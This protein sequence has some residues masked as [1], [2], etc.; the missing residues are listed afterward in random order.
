MKIYNNMLNWQQNKE[1]FVANFFYMEYNMEKTR[2]DIMDVKV[3]DFIK[4]CN[5]K[6]ICGN[7]ETICENFCKDSRE[8]KLGDTYLGIKG[9]N[10]NGS[11]YYKQA[12]ENGAKVLILQDVEVEKDIVKKYKDVSIIFV[13]NVVKAIQDVARYKRENSNVKVVGITGSVGKTS[14]KDI[15]ASVLSQKYKVL[16]T[17]GNYNNEIGLPLTILSLK[18]EEIMVL[19]MGMS[20]FGEMSLLTSI[21]KPD[22]AA[23]TNI[24]TSHIGILGS[25]E[26]ILKAKLEILEGLKEDGKLIINN[27][28]DLLNKWYLEEKTIS[29]IKTYG[30]NNNSNYTAYEIKLDEDGSEYKI[31]I[32][33]KI[34]NVKVPVN[35][36]HF[37]Y[38]S[39][40]AIA[41]GRELGV[42]NEDIIKGISCF[43]LT[44]KR[45]EMLKT[46]NDILII[47][48][49]YNASYDSMKAAIEYLGTL[50]NR[51]IAILG[52]MLELG[53]FSKEL[54]EKVGK[55]TAKN[56]INILITIGEEAKYIANS[57]EKN[58]I[59]KESI[60]EFN[61]REEA[62]IE[63]KKIVKSGDAILVKASN[64]MKFDEITKELL[65]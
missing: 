39:L 45:M 18:D 47:N 11:I 26:N 58:G 52:D 2:G 46:K 56:N 12:L 35:G 55:E 9:E 5:A 29:N 22:I 28:N 48:D 42:S 13:E 14:T 10:T 57:A 59:K 27:D 20:A 19:E 62:I 63:I 41:I 8:V 64:A 51:K 37:I 25:R 60:Y 43:E 30:I 32:D 34:Y 50:K 15:V 4:I 7:E 38:N 40:C 21:A 17:Q 33:N 6:L 65:K 23:I 44:K 16:K 24:G 31:D 49:C 54:H 1:Y 61:N 3:K 53:D 36:E